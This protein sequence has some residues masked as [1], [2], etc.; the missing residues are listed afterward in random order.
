MKKVKI[1]VKIVRKI[2]VVKNQY[3]ITKKRFLEWYF[4][5]GEGTEENEEIKRELAD[6]V[7]QSL[8]N[9]KVANISIENIFKN[10]NIGAVRLSYLNE[11]EDNEEN[12]DKEFWTLEGYKTLKLID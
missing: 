1:K 5:D 4:T 3:S 2:K 9:K 8:F 6:L 10:V 7:I 11:F 12:Y